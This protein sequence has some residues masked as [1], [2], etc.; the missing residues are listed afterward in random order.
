MFWAQLGDDPLRNKRVMPARGVIAEAPP[1]PLPRILQGSSTVKE[2]GIS[3]TFRL[4]TEQRQRLRMVMAGI[5]TQCG[6]Q[7]P[8]NALIKTCEKSEADV[9]GVPIWKK[10]AASGKVACVTEQGR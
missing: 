5:P 6:R 10:Y 3:T 7:Y 1:S 9:L 2:A 4:T 8:R